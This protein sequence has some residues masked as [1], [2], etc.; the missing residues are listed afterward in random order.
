VRRQTVLAVPGTAPV[1]LAG[2]VSLGNAG[3]DRVA[4][5][6]ERPRAERKRYESPAE[7]DTGTIA[8]RAPDPVERSERVMVWISNVQG[9]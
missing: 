6:T 2:C 5:D 8:A 1:T 4:F 9:M 3:G 7:I